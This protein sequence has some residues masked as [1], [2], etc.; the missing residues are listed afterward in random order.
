MHFFFFGV[1]YEK[2]LPKKD[3]CYDY[4]FM[5][6]Y[7]CPHVYHFWYF[8]C[9][10][11]YRSPFILKDCLKIS[12]R[13]GLSFCLFENILISSLFVKNFIAQRILGPQLTFALWICNSKAF[14]LHC[15]RIQMLI[16]TMV[17][18]MLSS[19]AAFKF[20]LFPLPTVVSLKIYLGISLF[21]LFEGY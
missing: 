10:P 6:S 19:F 11:M 3:Q 14:G 20:S 2:A 8:L 17:H 21:F 18:Y 9:I 5:E 12:C 13:L 4:C 15:L 16:L 1:I 7:I